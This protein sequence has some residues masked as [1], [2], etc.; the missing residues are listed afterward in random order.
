MQHHLI[1]SAMCFQILLYSNFR[2]MTS[3]LREVLLLLS[4]GHLFG[5][6]NPNQVADALAIPKASLYRHLKAFSLYQWKSLLVRIGC[7]LALAEIRDVESKSA[8]TRSR[9]CVTISVDDTNDP[10]Y[11]KLLSYCYKW[12]SKKHNNAIRGRNVLGITIKIGSMIIPLNLCI[13]SKQGRGN[14][15][16]LSCFVAMLKAVLDFFDTSGVDLRKYPI[17]FDSWYGSQNLVE[18][19]SDMGFNNILI[20]GKSNYVMDIDNKTAKLSAHKKQIQLRQKQWGCSKLS[21]RTKATSRTFGSFVLLFFLDMAK[22]EQ[23]W[24]L[25]TPYGRV[26]YSEYGLNITV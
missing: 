22:S 9:R 7:T 19:L 20:H 4:T 3:Q 1:K 8:A 17:T 2:K 6:Y 14:M 18:S 15:D 26:K 25:A 5:L 16:K 10:R 11:G 24:C 23:C 12:W 21:Y 13:V